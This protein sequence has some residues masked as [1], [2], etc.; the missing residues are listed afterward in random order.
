MAALRRFVPLAL[1][2]RALEAETKQLR[3]TLERRADEA[4][5][6]AAHAQQRLKALAHDAGFRHTADLIMANLHEIPNGA[7]QVEVLD[8]L[9]NQ[10]RLLKLKPTEKPQRTAENLY[11]KAKNQ[12]LEETPTDGAD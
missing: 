7:A 2:R 8:Y 1:S 6:A 5:A 10:P 11:R 4:S 12:H 3:Q 9:T